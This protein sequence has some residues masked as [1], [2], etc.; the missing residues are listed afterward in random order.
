MSP[1]FVPVLA[2]S[3]LGA[4]IAIGLTA[5]GTGFGM[6]MATGKAVESMARQ[7]EAEDKVRQGLVLGLAFMES[8]TIYGLV[9]ALVLIFANPFT[10]A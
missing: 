1:E 6:G 2:N 4:G 5:I 3:V 7:P 8:L 9:V 10:G